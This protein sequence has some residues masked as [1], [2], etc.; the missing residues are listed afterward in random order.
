M[1]DQKTRHASCP[2]TSLA[3]CSYSTGTYEMLVVIIDHIIQEKKGDRIVSCFA[4]QYQGDLKYWRKD[5]SA[6]ERYNKRSHAM[7]D[8]NVK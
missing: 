5:S 6:K 7:C 4:L 8:T 3:S 2:C 1:S